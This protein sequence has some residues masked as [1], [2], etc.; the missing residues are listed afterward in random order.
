MAEVRK[1]IPGVR[2]QII[3]D[4]PKR[5]S[6][7]HLAKSLGLDKAVVFFGGLPNEEISRYLAG[8]RVFVRPSRSEGMGNAFLEALAAGLPIVGTPVGGITDIIRDGE[9]GLFAAVDD[10]VGLASKVVSILGDP[11]LASRIVANGRKMIEKRFSWDRIAP[12]FGE[13]FRR[14]LSPLRI[15]IATPMFPPDIGGPGAYAENLSKQFYQKGH[16]V[17]ILAYGSGKNRQ[18]VKD[19][20]FKVV[21]LRLAYLARQIYYFW[22]AFRLLAESDVALALD[23]IGVGAPLAAA[24]W[25][26]G[27]PMIVRLE[28]DRLWELYVGRGG[29]ELTLRQFYEHFLL[30]RFNRE[31][32]RLY[33]IARWAFGRADR[34]VFSSEWRKSIFSLGYPLRPEQAAII[35][36][37]WP[38][39]GTGDSER[40]RTLIF[41][42]RFARVKNLL[43]L[44][45]A[46]LAAGDKQWRLEL[47]GDGPEKEEIEK[48]IREH[49]AG[50]R[51]AI[52]PSMPHSELMKRI[53]SAHAFLLPSLSDVSPNVILD[54]IATATPFLLTR[55]TG[56]Y[57]TLKDIGIFAD[58]RDGA[59]IAAKLQELLDPG[60]YAVY[61]ERVSR[62][63]R[64]RLW[65]DVARDWLK[66]IRAC[67]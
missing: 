27:K 11:A 18:T 43:R 24:C 67:L 47:I 7:E 20:A 17:I 59:D 50:D 44:I 61:R 38:K 42:G 66:I 15:L 26:R 54:C 32:R 22:L 64:I 28:G 65:D 25:L 10:P 49:G 53:S 4:G 29:E 34:I 30:E 8:A 1:S 5:E 48:I 60:F 58:P 6:L 31:E 19:I 33:K 36:S 3:G 35:D 55:E 21:P 46:F 13:L 51:I 57:D 16:K 45:R 2:W 37:P 12:A 40:N 62:F 23:P 14:A 41:A 39:I 52:I 56:F 63:D 9:T